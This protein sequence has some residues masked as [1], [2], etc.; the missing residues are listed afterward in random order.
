M[1]LA[2][3]LLHPNFSYTNLMIDDEYHSVGAIDRA[4]AWELFRAETHFHS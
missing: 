1:R 3:V 2:I 4:E